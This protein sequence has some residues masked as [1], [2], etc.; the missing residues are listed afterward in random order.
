MWHCKRR[1]GA[2][3]KRRGRAR[4]DVKSEV[5]GENRG[6]KGEAKRTS[7]WWRLIPTAPRQVP[8]AHAPKSASLLPSLSS[9]SFLINGRLLPIAST[10]WMAR[11]EMMGLAS[12]AQRASTAWAMAFRPEV[13]CREKTGQYEGTGRG[14]GDSVRS[15]ERGG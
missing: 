4:G 14:R 5:E 11:F 1:E 12:T 6:R 10:P 2:S 15:S 9:G 3:A 13:I 8:Q 7:L